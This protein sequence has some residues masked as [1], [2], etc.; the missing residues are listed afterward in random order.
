M[1]DCSRSTVLLSGTVTITARTFFRLQ[2]V[3][4]SFGVHLL[5]E[6]CFGTMECFRRHILF[7][8]PKAISSAIVSASYEKQFLVWMVMLVDCMLLFMVGVDR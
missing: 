4:P 1:S 5:F 7:R 3:S 2:I 8:L 6:E